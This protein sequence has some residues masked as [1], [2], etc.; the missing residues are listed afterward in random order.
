MHFDGNQKMRKVRDLQ[1]GKEREEISGNFLSKWEF[2]R[3]YPTNKPEEFTSALAHT[4]T[5]PVQEY[6]TSAELPGKTR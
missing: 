3:K 2:E 6:P 5:Y 1:H 4:S